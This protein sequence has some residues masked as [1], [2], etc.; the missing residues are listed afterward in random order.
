MCEKL[1]FVLV[2]V[3]CWDITSRG[4]EYTLTL[5]T[6]DGYN[7]DSGLLHLIRVVHKFLAMT[8]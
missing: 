4:E 8:V 1:V 3:Y 7:L 2:P 5:Y 6:T